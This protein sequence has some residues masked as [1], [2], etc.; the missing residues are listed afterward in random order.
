MS[1]GETE[2]FADALMRSTVAQ[3][4]RDVAPNA[5]LT[6]GEGDEG[7]I[8]ERHW[9]LAVQLG[10]T[11]ATIDTAG[12][13]LGLGPAHVADICE[14]MGRNLFC[15]P[16]AETAV[17]LPALARETA[18]FAD[19]LGGVATGE[20]RLAYAEADLP[21]DGGSPAFAVSPVEYG[22]V[23]THV[24]VADGFA[25]GL[26]LMLVDAR[27]A[28]IE[29]LRAMDPTAPVARMWI[30]AGTPR[31]YCELSPV[32]A[33]RAAAAMQVAVASDMLGL[34]EAALARTV[35]HVRTRR[36]FGSAIGSFQATKHRLADV[37]TG[38]ASAR[39]CIAHAARAG[40]G[41]DDARLA[42]I[43]AANAALRATAA[44]VQLHGGSGFSWELDLHLYLKRARRLSAR[45][46]GTAQLRGA[47]ADVYIEATLAAPG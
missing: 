47:V 32:S 10:L 31:R 7:E 18:E 19:L 9:A 3:A 39:L 8:F 29:P 2:V 27:D 25:G 40:A 30:A 34:G 36:Q 6:G 45:D 20:T 15:G 14:E 37:R 21:S 24:L 46:G 13:G 16:F 22:P 44:A 12:G 38:L 11:S 35:E 5:A 41:P 26:R 17:L 23:A 43:V 42:R 33:A 4:L 1:D 28:Q